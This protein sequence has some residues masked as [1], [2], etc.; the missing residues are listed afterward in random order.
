MKKLHGICSFLTSF[1]EVT[2]KA[3][4]KKLNLIVEKSTFNFELFLKAIILLK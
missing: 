1:Y 3:T 4:K 2:Y